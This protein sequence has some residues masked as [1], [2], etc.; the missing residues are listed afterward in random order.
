MTKTLMRFVLLVLCLVCIA[1]A[2]LPVAAAPGQAAAGQNMTT[3]VRNT[4]GRNA[5]I[6]GTMEQGTEVDV[7][8]EKGDFFAVNC[9]GM[10]GYIRKS[11]LRLENE[12]YYVNCDP[13]SPDT[14]LLTY[15]DHADALQMRHS[16]LALARKQLGDPYVYGGMRPGGFDCSGLTYYLFG[17]HDI[18]LN[19]TA[20]QQLECG[21]VVPKEALQVGDLVFFREAGCAKPS[22]HVGIYVGDNH[23]IHAGSGGIEYADL[24]ME[25][26]AKYYIGARR[27]VNTGAAIVEQTPVARTA[28]TGLTVNSVTGRTAN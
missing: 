3:V 25:Y 28:S 23:M 10:T 22:S 17:S 6:V 20:S 4:V 26:Y 9:Y 24:D 16:L 19:R 7:L 13:E 2:V 5:W 21:I 27:V 8:D 1:A 12:T 11:Q 14:R 18:T 15:T